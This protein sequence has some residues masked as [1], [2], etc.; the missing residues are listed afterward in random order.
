MAGISDV[1]FRADTFNRENMRKLEETWDTISE[2]LY[3][4][5]ELL[6]SFG[7]SRDN[8][9]A[10][11]VLIPVAYYVH[12]RDLDD[13]YLSSAGTSEDRQ[14]VRDWTVR[15][16][17]MPGIFGSGLDTLLARLRRA[18]D[19]AGADGFPSDAIEDSM[20]AMGK[21]LRFDPPTV[22]ELATPAT[23]NRIP[24]HSFRSS[25][26][27]STPLGR[28]HIDHI[29]PHGDKLR[30]DWLRPGRLYG[31]A[32]RADCQTGAG[33]PCQPPAITG[34][35]EHRQE[36]T[37]TFGVGAREVPQPAGPPRIP[38]A[39]NDMVDLPEPRASSTST[40]QRRTRMRERLVT[41]LGREPGH[42]RTYR[43]RVGG[44]GVGSQPPRLSRRPGGR[45]PVVRSG[46][47]DDL[48]RHPALLGDRPV[49]RKL[50]PL[51]GRAQIDTE[52][53]ET[54]KRTP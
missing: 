26:A 20:A 40:E 54:P 9:D 2:R 25:T 53:A 38:R 8:I 32:G 46:R 44:L 10:G 36:R 24:L 49:E 51:G 42:W 6:A 27:M 17:L 29:F 45:A 30:R 22:D 18:I 13:R 43:F 14:R 21:S 12:H 15:A 1:G 11:M 39:R 37:A 50:P 48:V 33:Q 23:D 34:R 16:L 4:A 41:V 7:L 31:G 28:Y 47:R 5:A 19:D 52:R 35:G 3:L